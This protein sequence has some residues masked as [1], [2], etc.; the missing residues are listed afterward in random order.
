MSAPIQKLELADDKCLDPI[1]HGGDVH[2]HGPVLE[3]R[4]VDVGAS[5]T[6]DGAIEAVQ[7]NVTGAVTV[8]GGVIGKNK[9]RYT[10]GGELRCRFVT[11]AAITTSDN[12]FVNSEV[13]HSRI[14]TLGRL[15]AANGVIYG[16][17]ISAHTGV[18]CRSLGHSTGIATFVEVGT[19]RAMAQSIA[20]TQAQIEDNQKR[21]NTVRSSVEPL[22]KQMKNLSPQQREK[23]T[24]LLYEA[25]EM[26]TA[27]A[28]MVDA[29]EQRKRALREA[30]KPEIVVSDV[31]HAGVTVKLGS[32]EGTISTPMKGP[33]TIKTR[34]PETGPSE[35]VIVDGRDGTV[36]VL[37]PKEQPAAAA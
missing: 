18:A 8:D 36:F 32:L 7:L 10:V 24:E 30:S 34:K 31:V 37:P 26:E 2:V 23:A 29:L 13:V 1:R 21:V 22:L 12:I 6:V 4:Q 33:L 9:G 19:G 11:N 35:I 16:G 15:D 20:A 25:G 17:D 3:G 5:L 28:K 27:T 14:T